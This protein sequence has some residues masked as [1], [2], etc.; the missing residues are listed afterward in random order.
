[1]GHMTVLVTK[2]KVWFVVAGFRAKH[3]FT[4]VA[5]I[6][7]VLAVMLLYIVCTSTFTNSQ[8]EI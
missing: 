6:Y 8:F 3:I 7:F 5:K 4:Q 1:M 2:K